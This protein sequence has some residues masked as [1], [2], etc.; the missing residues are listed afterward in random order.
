MTATPPPTPAV[1]PVA[2]VGDGHDPVY[3]LRVLR[4]RLRLGGIRTATLT[5]QDDL[6]G[7]RRHGWVLVGDEAC[8]LVEAA[9]AS[10][11][12]GQGAEALAQT[13]RHL[14]RARVRLQWQT[15]WPDWAVM[16]GGVPAMRDWLGSASPLWVRRHDRC[17]RY[18]VT[19][20]PSDS[21]LTIADPPSAR[22]RQADDPRQLALFADA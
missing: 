11:Y 17:D 10:G 21:L 12:G 8:W 13:V 4:S 1:D 7:I 6:P 2:L 16:A 20:D 22:R 5:C 15:G 14:T 9:F 19:F 18:G 3:T